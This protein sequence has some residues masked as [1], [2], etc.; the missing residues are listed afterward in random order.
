MA[1]YSGIDMHAR[2]T[3]M[4]QN[5][6]L[7][8][9]GVNARSLSGKIIEV[10]NLIKKEQIDV[11]LVCETWLCQDIRSSSLNLPNYAIYRRDRT[12][13]RTRGG[14][15]IIIRGCFDV[16]ERKDLHDNEIE[17]VIVELMVGRCSVIF[18]AF[19][20]CQ[21][22]TSTERLVL[23][24]TNLLTRTRGKQVIIAGDINEN[25]FA[26]TPGSRRVRD[27]I[28]TFGLGQHINDHTRSEVDH[29]LQT[30]TNSL[31]DI[32]LTTQPHRVRK[33]GVAYRY[34]ISDHYPTFI[35]Y[36]SVTPN[37]KRVKYKA[38]NFKKANID[39]FR[40]LLEDEMRQKNAQIT[41]L[42]VVRADAMLSSTLEKAA[43]M[44]F[45]MC[46]FSVGSKDVPNI[47]NELLSMIDKKYKLLT[48]FKR[49]GLRDADRLAFNRQSRLVRKRSIRER[50]AFL[51]NEIRDKAR[52]TGAPNSSSKPMWDT[53]NDHL[54]IKE[55]KKTEDII[56]ENDGILEKDQ[57]KVANLF[58]QHFTS[59]GRAI[60]RELPPPMVNPLAYMV[61]PRDDTPFRVRPITEYDVNKFM[62]R[63]AASKSSADCVP[64]RI[65][66]NC[67]AILILAVVHVIN[68]SFRDAFVPSNL[69]TA[70]VTP[71]HKSGPKTNKNN[72]RPI[73]VLPFVTKVMEY[74]MHSELA[75]YLDEKGVLYEKQ[76]AYRK[77]HNTEMLVSHLTSQI[78]SS[79]EGSEPICVVFIDLK[80]AFDTVSIDILLAKLEFYGVRGDELRWFE[81]LLSGRRQRTRVNGNFSDFLGIDIGV[82][83]GSALG[84]LLFTIFMNDLC[85]F[86]GIPETLLYAD[87]TALVF[88]GN[89]VD[90]DIINGCLARLKTWMEA[91][92]MTLNASK[93]KLMN[94]SGPNAAELSLSIGNDV[95]EQVSTY[96]YLGVVLDPKLSFSDHIQGVV[97]KVNRL[98]G[99]IFKNRSFLPVAICEILVNALVIPTISY[100]DTVYAHSSYANLSKLDVAFRMVLRSS[101]R[102]P[103]NI[104]TSEIY[105]NTRFLPLLLQRQISCTK[106]AMKIASGQCASFLKNKISLVDYNI[107]RERPARQA[108]VPQNTFAVPQNTRR[109][110]SNANYTVWGPK[111]LNLIPRNVIEECAGYINP[112]KQLGNRLKFAILVWFNDAAWTRELEASNDFVRV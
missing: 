108:A 65:L 37:I 73:S 11:M 33:S 55:E 43:N 16:K 101:Y 62:K 53:L 51:H 90:S 68:A 3:M 72:F 97:N 28:T 60:E 57:T 18:C 63:Q 56:L 109:A 24:L 95:I 48:K 35:H 17:A 86:C 5:K 21:V 61:R 42:G 7:K 106:F 40:Q 44:A 54:P 111:T 45:P 81:S 66:K 26:D 89:M 107:I 12:D 58:N 59:V 75:Q 41:T 82:P 100:A 30:T 71:L 78:Y 39:R 84:P 91:N 32:I 96:K 85:K 77:H 74:H 46:V 1:N 87:D 31:L 10:T 13:G 69:K 92:R 93:T 38:R 34:P 4:P 22:V 103:I 83:Q 2:P 98:N 70:T 102:L 94:F 15:A 25:M 112:A 19:Y 8:I 64:F 9:F 47:S 104:S 67:F 50:M 76:A 99:I 20:K 52:L 88:K 23:F 36:E 80:K 79:W 49:D 29:F 27:L 6:I 110:S 14:V 105:N